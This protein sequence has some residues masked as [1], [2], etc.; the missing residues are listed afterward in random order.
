M[1]ALKRR[2][3]AG[4]EGG[5][6]SWVVALAYED[7][8]SEFLDM[9]TVVTTTPEETIGSL[10][11]WL[12]EKEF[13][14]VGIASF[15]PVDA[16]KSSAKYGFI[17]STP[18]PNWAN[19]DVIG[20]LGMRDEFKHIPFAFDTDVNAPALAEYRMFRKEGSLSSAYITVGTG[21][22]VGLV[23]N[24]KTVH[25]LVHP[26]GGHIQVAR[27]QGDSAFA[28]TCPFH[29]CCIEGMASSGAIA[30]RLGCELSTLPLLPD[31]DEVWDTAAY[32]LAQ[33]CVTLVLVNSPER[34]VLG[35]GLM[36]RTSLFPRIRKHVSM[37]LNDYIQNEA[38]TTDAGLEEYIAPSVWGSRAGIV[39]AIYLA[40]EALTGETC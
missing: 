40:N 38:L 10:R 2:V 4:V 13:D 1:A 5:G 28:G 39:G 14:A 17:T 33:L 35:G 11:A 24:G 26:E 29:A 22:G 7:S 18:K 36:N 37:L 21:I 34:I 30:A 6:Q 20:L 12:R 27:K 31:E 16:K 15:G 25:G 32:Y 19:T 8:L 23:C 3:L 9:L